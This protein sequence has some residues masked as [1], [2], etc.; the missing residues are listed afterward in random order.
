MSASEILFFASFIAAVLL[1]LFLDLGLFSKKYHVVSFR[2]SIFWTAIWVSLSLGFYVFLRFNGNLVHDISSIEQLEALITRYQ[3]PI[4]IAGLSLAEAIQVYNI[5]LGLE[6]LTGY[7]I[8]YAL[9]VDNVFVMILIFM[10]FGVDEKYYKKV[11]FWGI[12]GAIVMRFLFIFLSA[13]LIQHFH[14]ILYLFGAFLLYTAITMF[15]QSLKGVKKEIDTRNHPVVRFLSRNFRVYHS[16]VRHRFFITKDHKTYMTPLFVVLMVIEFSDVIFAVDSVPAIFSVTKDPYIVFFSNIFAIIGLRS[17]FFL[18]SNM[19]S[20]FHFLK[21]GL[22]VLLGFVG[23]KMLLPA[24]TDIHIAT[25]DSLLVIVIILGVS[26]LASLFVK[27][28][29]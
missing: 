16:Y 26:V 1:I 10:S 9:S 6:Y 29:E 20:R 18:V 27:R 8:E 23:V 5:N 3:H 11:L 19:V 17:L 13:A 14:W 15:Y 22:S 2:E 24:I 25:R 4:D 21:Y 28:K 7:I 12:L